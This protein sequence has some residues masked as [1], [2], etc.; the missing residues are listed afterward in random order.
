MIY[1]SPLTTLCPFL[2][3]MK[4]TRGNLFSASLALAPLLWTTWTL[5]KKVPQTEQKCVTRDASSVHCTTRSA[6]LANSA[7][8]GPLAS[9]GGIQPCQSTEGAGNPLQ[10]SCLE[11]PVDRG[12]WWAAVYGVA[13]SRTQLKQLSNSSPEKQCWD[14]D[15]PSGLLIPQMCKGHR[16]QKRLL[17]HMQPYLVFS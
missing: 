8:S 1:F 12:V 6:N 13:Q 7:T 17:Q 2:K 9:L 3:R 4:T 5:Q 15:H 14:W 16:P 10:Y 11:N